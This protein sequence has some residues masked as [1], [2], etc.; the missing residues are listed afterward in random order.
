[1]AGGV[2]LVTVCALTIFAFQVST[3]CSWTLR[4]IIWIVFPDESWL[5]GV[6]RRPPVQPPGAGGVR[7]RH[8]LHPHG[9]VTV[10][11]G[12]AAII[13]SWISR[14][15]MEILKSGGGALIF[16][17]YIILDTQVYGYPHTLS[18]IPKLKYRNKSVLFLLCPRWWW[19]DFI[20]F[21]FLLKNIYLQA[22]IKINFHLQLFSVSALCIYID[23]L[24]L[25]IYIVQVF[26]QKRT[27]RE[28]LN[29]TKIHL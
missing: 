7:P 27:R 28:I 18:F 3:G 26:G 8:G 9:Q 16:S 17:F 6:A 15:Y 22:S 19:V 25:F 13:L 24:N 23:I 5:H 14:R 29:L 20:N 4:K 1:M 12:G 2:T 21:R 11:R 10:C